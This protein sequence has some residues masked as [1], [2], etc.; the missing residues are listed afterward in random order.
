MPSFGSEAAACRNH[1]ESMNGNDRKA[2]AKNTALISCGSAVR[3]V[4]QDRSRRATISFVDED[5][6]TVDVMY[7]TSASGP[8]EEEGLPTKT[9][10]ALL[11][12][13]LAPKTD[14]VARFQ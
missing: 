10:Q 5:A 14:E 13:E 2:G 8:E 6:G 4:K 9:I 11:P 1:A 7:S 12:F 3:V